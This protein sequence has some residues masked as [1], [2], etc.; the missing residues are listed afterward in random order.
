MIIELTDDEVAL[1]GQWYDAAAGESVS[2]TA[3]TPA[4]FAMMKALLDKFGFELHPMDED[5]AK[6]DF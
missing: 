4:S 1:I 2:T 6:A 3:D 5:R